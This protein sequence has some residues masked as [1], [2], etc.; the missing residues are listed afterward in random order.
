MILCRHQHNIPMPD[1]NIAAISSVSARLAARVEAGTLT[2]DPAQQSVAGALDGLLSDILASGDRSILSRLTGR[3]KLQRG[4]YI[5]GGV[6]RGKTMLMDMFHDCLSSSHLRGG[7]FRLHFH[8]FMVLAQDTIHAARLSG[9]DD[10][11]EAAATTL[12]ARGRVMC[13]DEMEVRDIADAMILARL[14]TGL[15][16]KGVVVVATSNRHADELYKNGL[17]RDRFLPFIALLKQRCQMLTIADGRDWRAQMLAGMASWHMPD[18]RQATAALDDAFARLAGDAVVGSENIRVAGRDISFD[19][20][21]GDVA[22]ISFANLCEMPL[23]ARDYLAIAGRFAGLLVDHV[24][25]LASA[26][27]PAARRFMW[28]VDALYDR[29]RFLVASAATD[30]ANLYQGHNYSFEF[31]RTVSRLGE[32]TRRAAQ[33]ETT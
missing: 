15:F 3:K 7:Q 32:M 10:P 27:E 25:V 26:N 18:D 14:F 16:D 12:A 22:R 8:D 6:G 9:S 24:P 21:A 30:I 13:F 2:A 31:E 19:R 29:Q 20:V 23:G 17:H 11:V 33:A 28:L 4:L 5:H 1:Q